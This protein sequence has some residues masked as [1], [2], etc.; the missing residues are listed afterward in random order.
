MTVKDDIQ[1]LSYAFL[2][3]FSQA[4]K[5]IEV[6]PNK[7]I[8]A[9]SV[10]GIMQKYTLMPG[11]MIQTCRK[12]VEFIQKKM[13]P[14]ASVRSASEI[15]GKVN[16]QTLM[17]IDRSGGLLIFYDFLRACFTYFWAY[18]QQAPKRS[19]S[20]NSSLPE[21]KIVE[22]DEDDIGEVRPPP[23]KIKLRPV[24]EQKVLERTESTKSVNGKEEF[25]GIIEERF[26]KFL[27]G[28]KMTGLDKLE[29]RLTVIDEF[30]K[31]IRMEIREA[32][33][34]IFENESILKQEIEKS[35]LNQI[36]F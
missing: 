34:E 19:F 32:F 15:L 22:V 18:N 5:D 13:I 25:E 4:D 2:V 6:S 17:E 1:N 24:Y 29:N 8:P 28:T 36:I 9:T 14:S 27:R 21:T 33:L 35:K 12:V 16:Q 31:E 11:K 7:K 10:L 3:L 23:V 20:P 26:K 30:E